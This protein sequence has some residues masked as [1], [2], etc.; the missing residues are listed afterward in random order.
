MATGPDTNRA[1]DKY[2]KDN[3]L[4]KQETKSKEE[5]SRGGAAIFGLCLG[6]N[7]LSGI[8]CHARFSPPQTG[9]K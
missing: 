2:M 3:V 1:L 7:L 9:T 4:V 5:E 6:K 8:W